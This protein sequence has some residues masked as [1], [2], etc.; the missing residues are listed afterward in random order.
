[1]N[2]KKMSIF[3]IVMVLAFSS[4]ACSLFGDGGV[5]ESITNN[6]D[7][8]SSDFEN[9]D[10]FSEFADDGG[11]VESHFANGG[12]EMTIHEKDVYFWAYPNAVIPQNVSVSV[13]AKLVDG[14][15]ETG[16][17]VIC[18]YDY[19]TDNGIYFEITFDGFFVVLKKSDAGWEY[20]QE[21]TATDLVNGTDF[22][23]IKAVCDNGSYEFYVN[24]TMATSFTDSTALGDETAIYGYTYFKPESVILFDNF[25]AEGLE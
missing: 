4:L 17:G 2:M 18:N 9:D 1:M 10:L 12:L 19:D 14:D 8:Y 21:F 23:N 25:Y 24:G 16:A 11:L 6:K 5:V 22:N 7:V 3:L 13:D 20:L 15:E